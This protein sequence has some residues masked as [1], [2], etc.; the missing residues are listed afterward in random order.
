MEDGTKITEAVEY[1]A[2]EKLIVGL[3]S[4]IDKSTGLA[5]EKYFSALSAKQIVD[6]IQKNPKA[7]YVQVILAKANIAGE[8][9]NISRSS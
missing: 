4:P 2:I 1:D 8:L 7:S 6:A 5:K 3:V 9:N